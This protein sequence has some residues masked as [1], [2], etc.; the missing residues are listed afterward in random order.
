MKAKKTF[1]T[2]LCCI[3][4]FIYLL[5][6]FVAVFSVIWV[7]SEAEKIAQQFDEVLELLEDDEAVSQLASSMT[8]SGKNSAALSVKARRLKKELSEENFSGSRGKVEAAAKE[9]L[10]GLISLIG[11]ASKKLSNQSVVLSLSYDYVYLNPSD[12]KKKLSS[13]RL[14]VKEVRDDFDNVSEFEFFMSY[15]KG[16]NAGIAYVFVYEALLWKLFSA[17]ADGN[18]I[19]YNKNNEE[20]FFDIMLRVFD[21]QEEIID[22]LQQ[23][24]KEWNVSSTGRLVILNNK[25]NQQY[26]DIV[27]ERNAL[28]AQLNET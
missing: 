16:K 25:L 28:L 4:V 26:S 27:Q 22:F 15:L 14:L 18:L 1:L 8:V 7:N 13:A 21:K 19:V 10:K 24:Q 23:N 12:A 20:D 6:E 5:V 2:V 17:M 9:Y 3:A 11:N